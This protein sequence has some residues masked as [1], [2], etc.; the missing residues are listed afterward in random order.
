M[1]VLEEPVVESLTIPET[2]PSPIPAPS[3]PDT[4]IHRFAFVIHPLSVDYIRRHPGF[5]WTRFLP[6]RLVESCGA[7][8]PPMYL[9]RIKGGRSEATGQRIEGFLFSI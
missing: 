9:S 2:P 6:D 8:L 7:L 1:T 5:R 4:T 3:A